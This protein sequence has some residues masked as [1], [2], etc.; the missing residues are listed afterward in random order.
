ME[1]QK[2]EELCGSCFTC[3][4]ATLSRSNRLSR[5]LGNIPVFPCLAQVE[6]FKDL[7]KR[8]PERIIMR[9]RCFVCET[10]TDVLCTR[11]F[12]H[13]SRGLSFFECLSKHWQ[14]P[15]CSNKSHQASLFHMLFLHSLRIALCEMH[16]YIHTVFIEL[17]AATYMHARMQAGPS[18]H[19]SIH[20]SIHPS[21]HIH[22]SI[23]ACMHACAYID[24]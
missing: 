3:R 6:R 18:I 19:P 1:L 10:D 20:S 15:A 16:M 4:V 14:R 13:G 2:V 12:A 9:V 5:T 23:H 8:F 22:S 21:I 11:E 17:Y 24:T 7:Q